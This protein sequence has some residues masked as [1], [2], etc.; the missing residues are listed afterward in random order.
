MIEG[1]GERGMM[2]ARWGFAI[3]RGG[4]GTLQTENSRRKMFIK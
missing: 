3:G 4:R 2:S 1:K